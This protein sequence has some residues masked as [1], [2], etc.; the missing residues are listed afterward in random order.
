MA[1]LNGVFDQSPEPS[2]GNPSA[3]RQIS[4]PRACTNCVRARAKCSVGEGR[5]E[6]YGL[7]FIKNYSFHHKLLMTDCRCHRMNKDCMPSPPMRKRRVMKR[8]SVMETS[9]LEQKLDGIVTLLKS[10]TQGV[11]VVVNTSTINIPLQSSPPSRDPVG[12]TTAAIGLSHHEHTYARQIG[13]VHDARH[14]LTPIASSSSSSES[15]LVNFQPPL[16]HSSLQP[17]PEDAE[18]YLNKFRTDFAKHLPFVVI[19]PFITSHQLRQE[20]PIL[21]ICIMAVASSNST[22]Q[23]ALSKEVRAIF[24]REALVERTKNMDLLLGILVYAVW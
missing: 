1:G 13:S 10:A 23:I 8:P 18:L 17:S 15:A 21:W 2:H 3:P 9:K 7:V 22:Q 20:R 11:P 16:L 6:R 24:G 14:F 5:C 12:D 4:H 19:S